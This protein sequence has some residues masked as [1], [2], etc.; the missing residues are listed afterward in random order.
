MNDVYIFVVY[1]VD[2]LNC[3]ADVFRGRSIYCNSIAFL[4]NIGWTNY[5]ITFLCTRGHFLG[6]LRVGLPTWNTLCSVFMT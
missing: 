3:A 4:S 6:N 5:F 2:I 1:I